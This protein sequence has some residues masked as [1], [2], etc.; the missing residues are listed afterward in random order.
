MTDAPVTPA[1]LRQR[2][3]DLAG[4]LPHLLAEAEHLASTVLL[5]AHGR[6]GRATRRG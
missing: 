4:P 2:A 1:V 5:G 3:E 6:R